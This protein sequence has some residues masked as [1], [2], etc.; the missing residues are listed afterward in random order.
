MVVLK[1][2]CHFDVVLRGDEHSGHLLRR[3]DLK[4]V[5]YFSLICIFNLISL[6][7]P[8]VSPVWSRLEGWPSR[9]VPVPPSVPF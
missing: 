1:F 4:S 2:S 5:Q 7:F 8:S 9:S 6:V 3:P